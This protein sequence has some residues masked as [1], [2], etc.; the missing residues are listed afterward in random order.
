[1]IIRGK[2]FGERRKNKMAGYV[3]RMGEN[4]CV[5]TLITMKLMTTIFEVCLNFLIKKRK[6]GITKM[7][8]STTVGR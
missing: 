7:T 8:T 1:M 3:K 2:G 4:W 5:E 6:L